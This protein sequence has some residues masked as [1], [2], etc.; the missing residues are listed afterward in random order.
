MQFSFQK[1]YIN[2]IEI[3]IVIKKWLTVKIVIK[4]WLAEIYIL[5]NTN[6]LY[7]LKIAKLIEQIGIFIAATIG[8][9]N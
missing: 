2:V 4:K 9:T 5:F 6:N 7:I 1:H 8:K 3:K